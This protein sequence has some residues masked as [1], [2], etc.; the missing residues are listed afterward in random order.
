MKEAT[1]KKKKV[2]KSPSSDSFKKR[3][4]KVK[5]KNERSSIRAD[6]KD[7]DNKTV[8]STKGRSSKAK[9]KKKRS[10]VR[11][12]AMQNVH[13]DVTK[14]KRETKD[15]AAI[16]AE[17][18]RAV[19][20]G[21][22]TTEQ[23]ELKRYREEMTGILAKAKV[24]EDPASN[25]GTVLR[26]GLI[27]S[28]LGASDKV[29]GNLTKE[30]A[31]KVGGTAKV[32]RNEVEDTAKVIGKKTKETGQKVGGVAKAVGFQLGDTAK[33]SSNKTRKATMGA[34]IE[35]PS[36]GTC[37]REKTKLIPIKKVNREFTEEERV[38]ARELWSIVRLYVKSRNNI[39]NSIM[40][41]LSEKAS[42]VVF[43]DIDDEELDPVEVEATRTKEK[44]QVMDLLKQLEKHEKRI[45]KAKFKI[46]TTLKEASFEKEHLE[47]KLE[48]ELDRNDQLQSD[49]KNAEY[50]LEN[51]LDKMNDCDQ[52]RLLSEQKAQNAALRSLIS[53]NDGTIKDLKE[54]MVSLEEAMKEADFDDFDDSNSARSNNSIESSSVFSSS[55]DGSS[56]SEG[57][58]FNQARVQSDLLATRT[59]LLQSTAIVSGNKIQLDK[60][61]AEL[62]VMTETEYVTKLS[63]EK[64]NRE[65]NIRNLSML[66]A[67][68]KK[69][70][71]VKIE[72]ETKANS[73]IIAELES[74]KKYRHRRNGENNVAWSWFGFRS[75]EELQEDVLSSSADDKM[76][77]IFA[78]MLVEQEIVDQ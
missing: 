25:N 40:G 65:E 33:D 14:Q 74:M 36:Q 78:S 77:D 6:E 29:V 58:V 39:T 4:L 63:E 19:G 8:H 30:A 2:K 61:R 3:N 5:S 55:D 46:A 32:A 60:L 7:D 26:I 15:S 27:G 12:E 59:N 48:N 31:Q 16:E 13:G 44:K 56:F 66:F 11:D 23:Q 57:D 22:I 52:R 54:S 75:S 10:S 53:F 71:E 21:Q 62:G 35:S 47:M 68:E 69:C 18:E 20:S 41:A 67:D 70:L 76:A 37:D 51:Y 1:A 38:R 49:L 17:Q 9:K 34:I 43:D 24:V 28:K 72:K 42:L 64:V 45:S 50:A 73:D